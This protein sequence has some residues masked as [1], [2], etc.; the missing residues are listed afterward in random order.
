MTSGSTGWTRQQW[1][2]RNSYDGIRAWIQDRWAEGARI[3]DITHGSGLWAAVVAENTGI[4]WQSIHRATSEESL[5]S[6]VEEQWSD[7][8]MVMDVAFD[9]DYYW[10]LFS[11]G[12]GIRWPGSR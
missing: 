12:D 1:A 6:Y 4:G 5:L 9:G 11:D 8:R 2:T 7:G 3:T 10:I